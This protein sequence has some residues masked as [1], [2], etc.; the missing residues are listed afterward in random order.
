MRKWSGKLPTP[1]GSGRPGGGR[2]GRGNGCCGDLAPVPGVYVPV[3]LR[4]GLRRAPAGGGHAP[5][6]GRAGAGREAHHR[7]PGRL[8]VPQAAA[9]AHD[10]GGPRPAQRRDLPGL[11]PG[12]PLLP[13]GHDHPAGPGA[14]GRPGPRRWSATGSRR[15][16]YDEVSLTSLSSA[17]F[18]GHRRGGRRHHRRP[19]LPRSGLGEPAQPARRR[20]HRRAS[21]ARSR[22]C[23]GPD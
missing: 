8:A 22:R 9:G 13:G 15:T 14:A 12:L 5:L 10:R 17:D 20:L 19:G 3:L 4:R 16:G 23:A 11:H 6:P 21:P 18:S 7:R 2:P 1:C